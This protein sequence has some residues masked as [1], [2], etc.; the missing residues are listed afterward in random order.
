MIPFNTSDT[1]VITKIAKIQLERQNAFFHAEASEMQ[2]KYSDATKYYAEVSRLAIT[3]TP[4]LEIKI[5]NERSDFDLKNL[6]I[7]KIKQLQSLN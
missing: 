5:L 4:G 2:C 6:C 3:S 7:K 1:E